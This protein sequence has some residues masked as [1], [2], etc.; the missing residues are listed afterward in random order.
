MKG[1][2]FVLLPVLCLFLLQF[3]CPAA[4]AAAV[5]YFSFS[6]DESPASEGD[7]VRLRIDA[8]RMDDP[9]AGFRIRVGYDGDL[10]E[11]TGT[12][13]S[14]RV[15]NGTFQI[16]PDGNPIYGIY[17]C[18]TSKGY[19]PSL[20]GNIISFVFKVREGARRRNTDLSVS[21]DQICNF[22]AEQLNLTCSGELP[23]RID[24]G[25]SSEAALESLEPLAGTLEPEFSP[26]VYQYALRVGYDVD[27]VEFR[28]SAAGRGTVKINRKTLNR[29]GTDTQIVATV[30]AEDKKTQARYTVT[31]E[32]VARPESSSSAGSRSAPGGT[33]S[34][35]TGGGPGPESAAVPGAEQEGAPAPGSG[36][37]GAGEPAEGEREPYVPAGAAPVSRQDSAG[38]AE[39]A[40]R[41]LYFVGN[42]MPEYLVGM[43]ACALCIVTGI[44]LCLWLGIKPKK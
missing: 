1:R 17:V 23:L 7:T 16:N 33:V 8:N 38:G 28:A 36:N 41:N 44:A 4:E 39:T 20:S 2:S 42:R 19:A 3:F 12:E 40:T 32:R 27:S 21:V 43:L 35:V 30:T 5:P 22:D 11:F 18:D 10:L 6:L 15:G 25:P 26:D 29:A 13:T 37:G 31:V 24:P 34:L 9:A 14:S